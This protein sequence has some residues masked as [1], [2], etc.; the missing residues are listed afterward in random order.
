MGLSWSLCSYVGLDSFDSALKSGD[1]ILRVVI[2]VLEVAIIVLAILVAVDV[3]DID[4]QLHT[5]KRVVRLYFKSD[6]DTTTQA[7]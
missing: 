1:S 7:K 4:V 6:C 2:V 5:R 3:V